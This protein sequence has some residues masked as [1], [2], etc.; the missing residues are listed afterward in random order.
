MWMCNISKKVTKKQEQVAAYH[1]IVSFKEF[2][3]RSCNLNYFRGFNVLDYTQ[4]K[5]NF[6]KKISNSSQNS[7]RK[8]LRQEE[9]CSSSSCYFFKVVS[10]RQRQT[11]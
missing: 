4:E 1:T 7:N 6:W 2:N 10:S 9:L 3:L 5:Q 8:N 11:V